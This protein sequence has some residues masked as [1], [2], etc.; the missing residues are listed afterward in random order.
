MRCDMAYGLR[1]WV[2][3]GRCNRKEWNERWKELEIEGQR[4][5]EIPGL[6]VSDTSARSF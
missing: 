1:A 3:N 2:M 5:R 4:S 6:E